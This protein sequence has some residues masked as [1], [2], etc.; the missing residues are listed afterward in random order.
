M[1]CLIAFSSSEKVEIIFNNYYKPKRMV[2]LLQYVHP[3]GG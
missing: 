2:M 3:R 1:D